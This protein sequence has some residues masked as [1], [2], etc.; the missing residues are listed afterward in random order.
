MFNNDI[1][2]FFKDL[3]TIDLSEQKKSLIEQE[4][5]VYMKN[6]PVIE[7]LHKNRFW[8][9]QNTAFKRTLV[10]LSII[11]V[12]LVTGSALGAKAD[13]ALPG[14]WLYPVKIG[15]NEKVME[16]L[17]FS[18]E[19]KANLNIKLVNLRLEEAEKLLM[20]GNLNIKLESQINNDFNNHAKKASQAI[21]NLKNTTKL[22]LSSTQ[23]DAENIVLNFESSLRAHEHILQ[24][25]QENN[26]H[27]VSNSLVNNV[28]DV[29]QEM[30]EIRMNINSSESVDLEENK[31]DKE[32]IIKEKIS[33]TENS[34]NKIKDIIEKKQSKKTTPS[35][36]QSQTQNNLDLAKQK[37][38]QVKQDLKDNQDNYEKSVSSLQEAH[39]IANEF[40]KLLEQKN[41]LGASFDLEI[42]SNDE[43]QE[44]IK[45]S[46]D[47]S[48]I[49]DNADDLF[50]D[51]K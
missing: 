45:D 16:V 48:D 19:N 12:F 6:N 28:K 26:S 24:V 39:I 11:L 51:N 33:A 9:L 4:V 43:K 8:F 46:L 38:E 23:S 2:K 27:G 20:Q 21:N 42:D 18:E 10:T 37:I 49:N 30:S 7:E 25:L 22:N 32:K 41:N 15:L 44:K 36:T 50:D 13:S 34:V 17:A 47:E 3:K 29:N 31:I 35:A 5:F 40:K 1:R 14:D